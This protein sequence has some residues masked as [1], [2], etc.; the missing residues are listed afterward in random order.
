MRTG[1]MASSHAKFPDGTVALRDVRP[2][3][4]DSIQVGNG[5][6]WEVEGPGDQI[7]QLRMIK[8]RRDAEALPA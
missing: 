4:E 5:D 3:K 7:R 2:E 1:L 6:V 8:M